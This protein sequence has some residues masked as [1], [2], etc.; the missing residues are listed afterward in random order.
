MRPYKLTDMSHETVDLDDP[1]IYE[2]LPNTIDELFDR[3]CKNIGYVLSYMDFI[4]RDIYPMDARQRVRVNELVAK[5]WRE[6]K[7]Y[8]AKD[9]RKRMDLLWM[10]EQVFIF[11]DETENMC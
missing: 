8:D 10:K 1:S 5:F 6:E 3:M 7:E 4:H 2:Y 11:E 9:Q